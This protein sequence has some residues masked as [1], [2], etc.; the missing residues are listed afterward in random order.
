M[1]RYEDKAAFYRD[2]PELG[3]GWGNLDHTD[4]PGGMDTAFQDAY[5][6]NEQTDFRGQ[7][8]WLVTLTYP[9]YKGYILQ[10]RWVMED[11]NKS[12]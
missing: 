6:S 11:D 7:G 2:Y 8:N 9:Q 4:A 12:A 3:A 5:F 10:N 1:Q